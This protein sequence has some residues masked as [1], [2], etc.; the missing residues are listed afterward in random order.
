MNTGLTIAMAAISGIFLIYKWSKH[1][2]NARR[3][4]ASLA[5]TDARFSLKEELPQEETWWAQL[6]TPLQLELA[7]ALAMKALPV[8]QRYSETNE[9]AYKNSPIGAAISIRPALLQTSLDEVLKASLHGF[10]ENNKHIINIYN[11]FVG[12]LVALQDGHWAIP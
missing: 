5:S 8:W 6:D 10:P 3:R 4:I 7:G 12:P 9:L 2:G 11:E 1:W